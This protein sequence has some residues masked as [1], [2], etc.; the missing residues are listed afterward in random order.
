MKHSCWAMCEATNRTVIR[1]EVLERGGVP[2]R[3][4]GGGGEK[5]GLWLVNNH[6]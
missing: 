6:L 3:G 4:G 1:D 5:G 2:E